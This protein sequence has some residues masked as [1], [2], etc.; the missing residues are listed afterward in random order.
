MK[1]APATLARTRNGRALR[2]GAQAS[3]GCAYGTSGRRGRET[4]A[5]T[6]STRYAT[7]ASRRSTRFGARVGRCH[8][9]PARGYE[10]RLSRKEATEAEFSLICWAYF[11]LFWATMVLF[12]IFF[13]EI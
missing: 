9:L 6:T 10:L 7:R 11:V 8:E 13:V 5:V 12:Y 2:A 4:R 1:A 3:R